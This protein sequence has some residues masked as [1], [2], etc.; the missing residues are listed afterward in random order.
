MKKIATLFIILIITLSLC[1]CDTNMPNTSQYTGGDPN[2]ISDCIEDVEFDD[3]PVPGVYPV[4]P[5][6]EVPDGYVGIYTVNDLLRINSNISMN[7]ILMEDLDLSSYPDWEGLTNNAHFD[8]NGHTISNLRSE[9]S[10]LF[11]ECNMVTGLILK[12]V[13]IAF[14]NLDET[15]TISHSDY[16]IGAIANTIK[17]SLTNCSATGNI[18]IISLH[19]DVMCDFCIGGLVGGAENVIISSC[20]N[21]VSI[22]YDTNEVGQEY[23]DVVCGGIIGS[24]SDDKKSSSISWCVNNA[25]IDVLS[26]TKDDDMGWFDYYGFCGGV[27]GKIT[28]YID[29]DFCIN[30]GDITSSVIASGIVANLEDGYYDKTFN[31][32][33][34]VNSGKIEIEKCN[35]WSEPTYKLGH[36]ASG[37]IGELNTCKL[38]IDSCYSFGKICGDFENAGS[39]IAHSETD[40]IVIKN[41]IYINNSDYNESFV[42]MDGKDGMYP[43]SYNNK[44]I[45]LT[46]AKE[47]F[48]Q[49]FAN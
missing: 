8:G 31:V 5:V 1:A 39:L 42:S 36:K 23:V 17:K 12:N 11:D 6:S 48:S 28:P 26:Y 37:I 32:H 18:S 9:K 20:T 34:C 16:Y 35:G 21:D 46:R 14:N 27:V 7:Y 25:V 40:Q 30:T 41:C 3:D 29:I 24:V 33:N 22:F 47:Q 44:E 2:D 38:N 45:S 19:E 49:Y 13:E 15:N 4:T 43:E 10:G